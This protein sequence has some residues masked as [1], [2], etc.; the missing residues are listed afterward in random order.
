M[1]T[2]TERIEQ[3]LKAAVE[4]DNTPVPSIQAEIERL[5]RLKQ[6]AKNVV[7]AI[8]FEQHDLNKQL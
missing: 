6:M 1:D 5:E 2:I 7:E 3:L 8:I 4:M